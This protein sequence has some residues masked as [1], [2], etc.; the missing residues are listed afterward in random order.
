MSDS[1]SWED[2]IMKQQREIRI[3]SFTNPQ[4]E[5]LIKL[6]DNI[7]EESFLQRKMSEIKH[8]RKYVLIKIDNSSLKILSELIIDFYH[9]TQG[10]VNSDEIYSEMFGSFDEFANIHNR[11]ERASSVLLLDD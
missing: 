4:F 10:K 7:G 9:K 6:L 2:I 8:Y 11:L 3:I 5:S 1:F